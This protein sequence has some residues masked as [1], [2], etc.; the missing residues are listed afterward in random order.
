M[1][2]QVQV[3]QIGERKAKLLNKISK[4]LT[5]MAKSGIHIHQVLK[6]LEIGKIHKYSTKQLSGVYGKLV[7]FNANS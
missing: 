3:R 1:R 2:G 5:A 7:E 4:L 6:F